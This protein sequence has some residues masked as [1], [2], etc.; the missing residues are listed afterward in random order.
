MDNLTSK[1]YELTA[2]NKEIEIKWIC[3]ITIS[4]AQEEWLIALAFPSSL[5]HIFSLFQMWKKGGLKSIYLA[6]VTLLP[7][8]LVCI[9]S[10]FYR[11]PGKTC[12]P[13]ENDFFFQN[14]ASF[15]GFLGKK[16]IL[17]NLL[18]CVSVSAMNSDGRA[19]VTTARTAEMSRSWANLCSP[20]PQLPPSWRFSKPG[21]QWG[22]TFAPRISPLVVSLS[23][24]RKEPTL[25]PEDNSSR[26]AS[27]LL[28]VLKYH[29]GDRKGKIMDWK[30]KTLKKKWNSFQLDFFLIKSLHCETDGCF[31]QQEGFICWEVAVKDCFGWI[32]TRFGSLCFRNSGNSDSLGSRWDVQYPKH[33]RSSGYTKSF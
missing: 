24:T 9:N 12:F 11:Q 20:N 19:T 23:L 15:C 28:R 26:S 17:E 27:F 31:Y 33:R 30:W 7:K 5:D 29:L 14:S 21:Q 2:W 1:L 16:T 8:I 18:I 6:P 25:F 22:I 3:L 13:W 4:I 32:N 10:S